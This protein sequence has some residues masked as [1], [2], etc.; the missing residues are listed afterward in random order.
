MLPVHVRSANRQRLC[1]TGHTSMSPR[2]RL[3]R[4]T[5]GK[6]CDHWCGINETLTQI[7]MPNIRSCGENS[8]HWSRT[9]SGFNRSGCD[10][11][12]MR[13][14]RE[15]W[16]DL[17]R[18]IVMS[19]GDTSIET[20]LGRPAVPKDTNNTRLLVHVAFRGAGL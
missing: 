1:T 11:A 8:V 16:S 5:C 4:L 12:N 18:E 9:G 2:R 15:S 17:Y 7:G 13:R 19:F 6:Q 14:D 10:V 3:S 20:V